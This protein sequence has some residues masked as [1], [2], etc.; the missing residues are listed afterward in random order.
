MGYVTSGPR[1]LRNRCDRSLPGTPSPKGHRCHKMEDLSACRKASH[2][3]V[4]TC[5]KCYRLVTTCDKHCY[6]MR[7]NIAC[8][9]S[10]TFCGFLVTSVCVTFEYNIKASANM[11]SNF[12]LYSIHTVNISLFSKT[13]C[14]GDLSIPVRRSYLIPFYNHM[15]FHLIAQHNLHN[16]LSSEYLGCAKYFALT[17]LLQ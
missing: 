17:K 8:V 4:T 13:L 1:L 12:P 11:N 3:S 7:K 2:W 6:Q 16:L 9:Q 15:A 14:L 10:L 5:D